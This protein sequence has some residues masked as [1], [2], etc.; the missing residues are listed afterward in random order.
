MPVMIEDYNQWAH[1]H[2][3]DESSPQT[4]KAQ[5]W[6][7][8]AYPAFKGHFPENPV[9]PAVS[10]IDLSLRLLAQWEPQ[11]SLTDFRIE[12]TRFKSMIH[13]GQKVDIEID[14]LAPH[15]WLVT[16]KRSENLEECVSLKVSFFGIQG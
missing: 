7:D 12:K 8:E 10:I 13:P 4:F 1:V 16:W 9:L 15:N 11:L 2:I 5:L 14:H 3:L 6:V